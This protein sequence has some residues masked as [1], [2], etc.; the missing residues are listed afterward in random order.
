MQMLNATTACVFG[1]IKQYVDTAN[2]QHID[3]WI[4][5]DLGARYVFKRPGGNPITLRLSVENVLNKSYWASAS[6]G[7][8]SGLSR[9]A[10]RTF[11]L[12]SS[13]QF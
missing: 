1:L 13:F 4:R 2:T 10:S 7:Q 5:L 3:A 12:S 6:T 8:V 9:G 11:L